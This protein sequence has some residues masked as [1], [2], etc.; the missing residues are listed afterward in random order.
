MPESKPDERVLIL[1][2]VG[3]DAAAMANLLRA[4][5]FRAQVCRD[6]TECSQC[7]VQG[8]GALLITE[9]SLEVPQA[10]K[11]FETLKAQPPWSELPLIILTSGGESR[12]AKL[13]EV[14]A[15][16]AG[17]ITL[18]ERPMS[19]AT[20]WRA[21]EGALRSRRRQYQVRDLIEEEKRKQREL[22]E[23][24]RVAEKELAE[25]RLAEEALGKWAREPLLNE[26]RPAFLRYAVAA[27]TVALALGI[28]LLLDPLLGEQ[29]PLL[30]L[31]G[32]IAFVV[33]YGGFGPA[34][35]ATMAGYWAANWLFIPP[36]HAFSLHPDDLA[37]FAVYCSSAAL[38][39]AFG[40]ILR[41]AQV[42]AHAS[43]RVAVER[44]KQTEREIEERKRVEQAKARLAA[45][46]ESS[47]DAII[48]TDLSGLINSWNRGA[49]RLYGYT[50]SEVIGQPVTMLIPPD[51]YDEEPGILE[52]IRREERVQ[53]Y[54]TVRQRKD[55]AP[56]HVSLTVSPIYDERGQVVGASK[57]ARDITDRIR[58]EQALHEQL[59]LTKAITDNATTALF[60]MDEKQ[61]CVFMNPAA[62]KLT[63][64][65]YA[66]VSA[67]GG[68]LHD[69]VHH[70]RPDGTPCPLHECP[71]DQAFPTQNQMRG[72]EVFV[73]KDGHFYDVAFTASPMRDIAGQPV[74]TVIE[75][76][77]ITERKRMDRALREAHELL[78]SRAKHLENLVERRTAELRE[79]V[80]QLETFSYSIV[81]DMRA[82]LRSMRSFAAFLETEYHDKFDETGRSYLQ[83]IM[84]S[85][86][87]MD[88]LITDV[89]TYSRITTGETSLTTVDLDKLVTE[90]VEQYPQFQEVPGAIHVEHPLPRVRGNRALLTQVI[91][92]LL[93]NAVKFV[94]RDKEPRS[95]VRA[96]TRDDKI[97]L[98]VEDNGIGIASEHRE[99]IFGLFQRLHR[100]DEYA[101]T[102]V[103][104]AIVKKA[105]ERMGGTVGVE[106]EPGHG[107]RFWIELPAAD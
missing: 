80:Q 72:E 60:I 61:Q 98:W 82:P 93:G 30:T 83:R 103:G 12:V 6:L 76:Q 58:S 3:Q 13:L 85:A 8:A 34:L 23:A 49:E 11:L 33:W 22:E 19:T 31:L 42:H 78:N 47:E 50:P 37:A 51:R 70:T 77:D 52:R 90:I 9:E 48:S 101:G 14:A 25:R 81:H 5:G 44:Q 104:L 43:A 91:S 68:A 4:Q 15:S 45:I 46:V 86:L 94:P 84:S 55:G 102:G 64:F 107:S 66:E 32:A 10:E 100:P 71:I 79:T 105:V 38:I 35:F 96:E 73:H 75:V 62:E 99:K 74:G 59:N 65:T 24:R 92:N 106:S 18:L 56:F 21:V 87:R 54:E 53:N 95:I 97:R 39:I 2:P 69:I 29:V 67:R 27:A 89:L 26:R 63:G 1:A 17:S 57:I 7:I 36:R 88:A 28:R 40:L 16:A 41:R 20:L